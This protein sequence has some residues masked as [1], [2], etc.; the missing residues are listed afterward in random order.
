M[1]TYKG[2]QGYSVEVLASDPTPTE[3]HVGKLWYNTTAGAFKI[4]AEGTGAWAAGEDMPAIRGLCGG[5]G[6]KTAGLYVGGGYPTPTL[7]NAVEFDGTDWAIGGTMNQASIYATYTAGTQTACVAAGG[8]SETVP[9]G[10]PAATEEYNGTGWTTGNAMVDTGRDGGG[11]AGL[12]TAAIA[13]AG[14]QPGTKKQVEDYDGTNWTAGTDLSNDHARCMSAQA[15]T[16]TST[17]CISGAVPG[18]NVEE[19][20]GTSWTEVGVVNTARQYGGGTG[21]VTSALI[22]AGYPAAG[23]SGTK[24][25]ETEKYNGT[26]WTELGDITTAKAYLF[27]FGTTGSAVLAGGVTGPSSVANSLTNEIWSDP[28]YTAKTVTVS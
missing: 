22:V 18:G 19:W 1:A 26:A 12:Q 24:N 10:F 25:T 2:I 13:F 15:G 23:P 4:A 8:Y 7:N 17:L 11:C 16:S 3:N 28:V 20:N 14:N 9:A 27:G 21:T 5:C 6:T